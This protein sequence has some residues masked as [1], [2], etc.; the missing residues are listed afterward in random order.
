MMLN[1]DQQHFCRNTPHKYAFIYYVAF[2]INQQKL[3][4]QLELLATIYNHFFLLRF[5]VVVVVVVLIQ[6]KD[7]FYFQI[8][9]FFFLLKERHD[10]KRPLKMK[11][12]KLKSNPLGYILL[13]ILCQSS[14][15]S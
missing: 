10:M 12:E 3:S 6:E 7:Q 14:N 13:D 5:V 15:Q 9:L 11:N 1:E 4:L 2:C 8:F